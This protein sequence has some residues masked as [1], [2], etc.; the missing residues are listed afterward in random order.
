MTLYV[1]SPSVQSQLKEM[2][3]ASSGGASDTYSHHCSCFWILCWSLS[4]GFT[5]LRLTE[6]PS[7][8]E[9]SS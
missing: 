3:T 9:H 1:A 2:A 6:P 7:G 5:K 4:V 8:L